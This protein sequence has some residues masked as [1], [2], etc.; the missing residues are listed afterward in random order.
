MEELTGLDLIAADTK[1][2]AEAKTIAIAA[3]DLDDLDK[4]GVTTLLADKDFDAHG[5]DV[6]ERIVAK[7][8]ADNPGSS[9]ADVRSGVYSWWVF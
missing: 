5:D 7:L 6:V 9:E 2:S 4:V 1:L 3:A 8:L